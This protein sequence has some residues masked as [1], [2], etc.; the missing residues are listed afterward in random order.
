MASSCTAKITQSKG[1]RKVTDTKNVYDSQGEESKEAISLL[2]PALC[3]QL[4]QREERLLIT[5]SVKQPVTEAK[6]GKD[7]SILVGL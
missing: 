5:C 7:N 6:L 3:P 1:Q 2:L 4:T